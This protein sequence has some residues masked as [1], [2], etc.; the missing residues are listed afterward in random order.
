MESGQRTPHE[1]SAATTEASFDRRALLSSASL[2]AMAGGLTASYGTFFVLRHSTF[3]PTRIL[4][5]G[6]LLPEQW[7]FR[8]AGPWHSS[9][10][11]AC[12][13]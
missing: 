12:R 9:R 10:R 1:P 5:H 8:Q 13:W 6:I 4:G 11:K 7:I 3:I 2:L